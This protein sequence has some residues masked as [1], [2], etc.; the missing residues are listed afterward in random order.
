[1]KQELACNHRIAGAKFALLVFAVAA[2]PALMGSTALADNVI[3]DDTI[4]QGS[5]C[6]GLDCVNGE[7]FGFDTLRLKENNTRIKFDDTSVGAGFP[8]NDW[9]LVAN[10]SASGGR[11]FFGI[12]DTTAGRM[13]FGVSAGAPANSLWVNSRGNV[14]LGT[15]NPLLALH[16]VRTDT[17][18]IRLEQTNA[19]G[20]TAQTW[21][22]GANEANFFIRDLTGGSRLPFRIRPGAPTSSID[23]AAN[24]FVGFGTASPTAQ[25]HTTGTVRFQGL[26]GCGAGL[27]TD[28]DGNVSCMVGGGSSLVRQSGAGQ[29]ITVGVATDG[30]Q[31]AVNGTAG[32]RTITGVLAGSVASGSTE[33]INGDQLYT[34][35][36]RVAAAFG[37]GAGLDANGQLTSPSYTIQGTAYNNVGGAVSAIDTALNNMVGASNYVRV[38]STGPAASATGTDA[39][40]IGSGSSSSGLNSI[41]VG[42]GSTATQSGSIAVGFNSSSTGVN[43]IAIGT[44]A[45][46]TG[47]VAVGAAAS[48]ANG[49]AAFG[50]GA[51][52]TG[53]L[54]TAI[55]PNASATAANSTS[56]GAGS[57]NTVANTVSFGS[58]GNERRLTNVAA[59]ISQTDAVNVGQLQSVAAGFQTQLGS[60]QTQINDT[61]TEARGGVALALAA[62]G[63]R[64]DDRPGKLSLSGAFGNFKGESGLALGLGY[65]ATNRLRFN[66]SVSGVPNQG[67]VGGVVGGSI[68][69]N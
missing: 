4:I 36:Q 27:A 69:L 33:A 9:T 25:L 64:Y 8:A 28:A 62:S 13:I 51:V 59:G 54:S 41:A 44:G 38:N 58:V 47:S 48:A 20:F 46:A 34:A 50:D 35:N 23:I 56:I 29:P 52:A 6:I 16:L 53:S 30:T 10:D 55:G 31:V 18:A 26:S 2:V 5:A 57:T 32:N 12:E 3:P 37:G 15:D 63:L 60:L 1:M 43:S 19:G 61:R 67:S 40:A 68:T 11:N 22:I 65:A 24:G 14:G 49:G 39:T 66:A 42:T 7:S 17:P 21:D 45:T